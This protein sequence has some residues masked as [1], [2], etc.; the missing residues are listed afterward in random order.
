MTPPPAG[1]FPA[2]TVA[3]MIVLGYLPLLHAASVVALCVL[4][5]LGKTPLWVLALAPAALT[6]C[7]RWRC[8]WRS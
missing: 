1:T 4:P 2:R 7:R 3:V 5:L 6:W 8:V